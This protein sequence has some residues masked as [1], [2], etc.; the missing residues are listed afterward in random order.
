MRRLIIASM[1]WIAGMVAMQGQVDSTEYLFKE[2]QQGVV[3]YKDGRTFEVP[4][5]Y[6]LLG[7]KFLFVDERDHHTIKQ[8]AEPP[9]VAS[10]RINGEVFI[11]S[12]RGMSQILQTTPFL[13][14]EYRSRTQAAGKK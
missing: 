11:P 3:Y 6:N 5:N 12:R 2:F 4:L 14:V 9:K 7:E 10:V 8:F 1:C 13:E